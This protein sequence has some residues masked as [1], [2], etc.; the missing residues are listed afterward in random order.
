MSELAR[1]R[2]ATFHPTPDHPLVRTVAAGVSMSA[3]RSR[4]EQGLRSRES[5]VEDP[6]TELLDELGTPGLSSP[7]RFRGR[8]PHPQSLGEQYGHQSHLTTY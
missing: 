7:P 5:F 3:Q 8:R 4:I 2:H 1:T 6:F